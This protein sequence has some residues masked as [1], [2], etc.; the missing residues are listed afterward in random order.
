M[1][2]AS[3]GLVLKPLSYENWNRL[4]N[5]F[6]ISGKFLDINYGLNLKYKSILNK[7]FFVTIKV[8]QCFKFIFFKKVKNIKWWPE[9]IFFKLSA[10][11]TS[12]L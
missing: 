9:K 7:P 4:I 10:N 5:N 1:P 12:R 2:L 3:N 11:I 6:N 8:I